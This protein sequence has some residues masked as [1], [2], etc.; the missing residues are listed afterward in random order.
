MREIKFRGKRSD[1]GEWAYGGFAM[2]YA[3]FVNSAFTKWLGTVE[4]WFIIQTEECEEPQWLPVRPETVGQ[5][6]GLKDKNG[7]EIYEGDI[8]RASNDEGRSVTAEVRWTDE[9]ASYQLWIGD[10]LFAFLAEFPDLTEVIGN[11]HDNP[12]LLKEE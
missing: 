5:Y 9:D 8:V 11:I 12:E 10:F 7:R 4:R 6:T 1:N 3:P 2:R